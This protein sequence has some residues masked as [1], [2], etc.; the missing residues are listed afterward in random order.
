MV[1]D[2]I[3][4][5]NNSVL[6]LATGSTPIGMYEYLIELYNKGD[7]DFSETRTVNLDEYVGLSR[8][9]PQS[10]NYFMHEKF[11]RHVN[12]SK[13]NIYIPDGA[14]TDTEKVCKDYEKIIENI[15][16][17]DLQILGIGT[18][19]HIGFNEPGEAFIPSTHVVTLAE[20][21]II[22]NKRFFDD[23]K[24][25]PKKAITI[26]IKTI[27]QAKKIVL[28]A[29]GSGKAA[30]LQKALLWPITP[31]IPASILQLHSDCTIIGDEDALY[32][33]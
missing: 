8:D 31:G 16:G 28:L 33:L 19:G 22:S 5:K 29:S 14:D 17:I 7:I 18:D 30:I 12:I 4:K 32:L 20:S 27:F 23:K 25:V 1:L 11:F 21:T 13:E 24:D 26:G 3:S 15:G 6:G 2:Q 9:N 10:Y